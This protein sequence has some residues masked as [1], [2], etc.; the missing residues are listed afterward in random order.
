MTERPHFIF[1]TNLADFQFKLL[2]KNPPLASALQSL[3][4]CLLLVSLN[5]YPSALASCAMALESAWKAASKKGPEKNDNFAEIL[6]DINATL[7]K[8]APSFDFKNFR[9]LRNNIVHFGYTP[10]DDDLAAK[11]IFSIG[12][13][14]F[15]L[16]TQSHPELHIDFI[17]SLDP[18]LFDHLNVV[19]KING[20]DAISKNISAVNSSLILRHWIKRSL[21]NEP[22]WQDDALNQHNLS[23]LIEFEVKEELRKMLHDG[24]EL[25]EDFRCPVC[26]QEQLVVQLDSAEIEKGLISATKGHCLNCDL[27]FQPGG[28]YLL[29][30][31][32]NR[33]LGVEEKEKILKNYGVK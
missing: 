22:M 26:H 2:R 18:D 5:R 15:F 11:L 7:P 16:Y 8:E 4:T 10:K 24:W 9:I 28:N 13:P 3:E 23:G 25:C 14:A 30:Y 31:F 32:I 6:G 1:F 33:N 12:L 27:N 21:I 20:G 29:N 17:S 19:I